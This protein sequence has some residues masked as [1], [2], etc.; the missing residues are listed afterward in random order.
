[1]AI[2]GISF[3]YS[4]RKYSTYA[5]GRSFGG[6]GSSSSTTTAMDSGVGG[7]YDL[8]WKDLSYEVNGKQVVKGVTGLSLPGEITAIM[9]PSGG[10]KTSLLDL[11]GLKPKIGE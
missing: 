2:G 4:S 7:G 3:C 8:V 6:S 9:G 1:M 5:S 11:L 10:G